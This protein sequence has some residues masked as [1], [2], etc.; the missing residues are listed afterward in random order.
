MTGIIGSKSSLVSDYVLDA[1]SKD[2]AASITAKTVT[3]SASKVYDGTIL[4]NSNQVNIFTG[5]T[6]ETLNYA[7]ATSSD[8]FVLTL[9]KYIDTISL[10]NNGVVLASNYALPT[11][12]NI[13]APV[14]ITPAMLNV[15]ANDDSKIYNG[16]AYSGGNGVVYSGFVNGENSSTL[17][18]LLSYKG[19]SKGAI[20]AGNYSITPDALTSDNYTINYIDG[21][22]TVEPEEVILTPTI[23]TPKPPIQL[24]PVDNSLLLSTDIIDSSVTDTTAIKNIP[25]VSQEI[26]TDSSVSFDGLIV[27]HTDTGYDIKAI[28]I[29]GT[30]SS[31][32]PFT[33]MVRVK[34]KEGF[35]FSVPKEIVSKFINATSKAN[36]QEITA[37]LSNGQE[38]PSWL[39]FNKGNM[40]FSST[41]VPVGSLPLNVNIKVGTED[42]SKTIEIVIK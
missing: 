40:T 36:K 42:T 16:I 33:M 21:T 22:L 14:T 10:Q 30:A 20:S 4:L 31:D 19:T 34:V 13:N 27:G 11:L 26:E 1:T 9:A 7:G 38:L 17:G 3:L 41:N 29:Q 39:S 8:A 12:N 15:K 35:S 23:S 32:I 37:T 5:V 2:V 24:N 6:N 28:I 25:T 18:G